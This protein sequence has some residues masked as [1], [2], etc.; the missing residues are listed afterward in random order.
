MSVDNVE[1]IQANLTN[2]IEEHYMGWRRIKRD[3]LSSASR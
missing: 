2:N 1:G 3:N